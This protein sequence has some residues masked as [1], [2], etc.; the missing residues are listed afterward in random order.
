MSQFHKLA[1][2]INV[3][4][5]IDALVANPGLWDSHT[6]RKDDPES[7]HKQMSDIIVRYNDPALLNGARAA[8]NGP[9]IPVMWPAWHALHALRDVIYSLVA[10]LRPMHVGAVLITR[11][12]PGGRIETHIDAGWHAEYHNTKVYLP[13]KANDDCVNTCLDERAVMRAGELWTFNNLVPHGVENNGDS[14]RI[15]LIVCMRT[16]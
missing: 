10:F 12:P 4:P 3:Q 16:E 14:E 2:G 9:H 5:L 6:S 11:I 7:P 1:E 8:W 15:T 13:I